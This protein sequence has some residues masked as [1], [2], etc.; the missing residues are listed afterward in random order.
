MSRCNAMSSA[1]AWSNITG[2]DARDFTAPLHQNHLSS[3][4]PDRLASDLGTSCWSQS[5]R[6]GLNWAA[7]DSNGEPARGSQPSNGIVPPDALGFRWLPFKIVSF[8]AMLVFVTYYS[9]QV[10]ISAITAGPW[11]EDEAGLLTPLMPNAAQVELG[12]QALQLRPLI[13][14]MDEEE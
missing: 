2:L 8:V 3:L 12:R 5:Q 1:G 11:E 7:Y 14:T 6:E 10:D 13:A 4:P 9:T